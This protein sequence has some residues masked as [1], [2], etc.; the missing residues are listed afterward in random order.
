MVFEEERA[1][2]GGTS[3]TS[4]S[5][6]SG[7]D[8]C[9]IIMGMPAMREGAG[10]AAAAAAGTE[11]GTGR[12]E[13][14]AM[15]PKTP[16]GKATG[17]LVVQSPGLGLGRQRSV[18]IVEALEEGAGGEAAAAGTHGEEAAGGRRHRPASLTVL[19]SYS[20]CHGCACLCP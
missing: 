19:R 16:K 9:V 6:S 20:A 11:D 18:K 14:A 4:L 8:E 12:V 13:A 17:T 15:S 3:S 1:V 2:E 10:A 7:G 5:S